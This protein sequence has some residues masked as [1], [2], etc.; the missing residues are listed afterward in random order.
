[1]ELNSISLHNSVVGIFGSFEF[2]KSV[3]TLH[4][5]IMDRSKLL[6]ELS[7]I[8]ALDV[9]GDTT[10]VDLK[11]LGFGTVVIARR[12]ARTATAPANGRAVSILLAS[13]APLVRAIGVSGTTA[14]ALGTLL[15]LVRLVVL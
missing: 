10:D 14:P 11:G 1:M 4:Q 9:S 15:L 3:A 8:A 5:N 12:V 6:K 2:D 13:I 7:Q